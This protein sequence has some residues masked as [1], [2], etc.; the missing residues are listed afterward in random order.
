MTEKALN[1]PDG[2]DIHDLIDYMRQNKKTIRAALETQ[3]K[4]EAGEFVLVPR[5]PTK[6]MLNEASFSFRRDGPYSSAKEARIVEYKAMI[7][8]VQEE[9]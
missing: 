1:I 6:N 2:S 4:I 3:K 5:E 7:Q 9:Q 8:A